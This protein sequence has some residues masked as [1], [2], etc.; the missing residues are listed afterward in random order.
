MRFDDKV[1]IVTGASA[2]IG[3]HA[4]QMF[5]DEGASLVLAAR[6]AERLEAVAE[7]IR[8]VKGAEVLA[9]P[10]DVGDHAQCLALID[11]TIERFGRLDV[12]VNNAGAHWRGAFEENPVDA[13]ATMV[14]VNLR[15]PIVLTRHALEHVR[16]A[17]GAFVHVAS[18]AGFSP[19]P[20]SV[21]YSATKAGLRAFSRALSEELRGSG[22]TSSLVSPGPV[23]TGFIMD[24]L[25]TVTDIT[26]SQP[27]SSAT[28]VAELVIECAYDG[29]TERA[30]PASSAALA[31]V[32]YLFPAV[33]RAIRPALEAKGRRNKARHLKR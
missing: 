18:I 33:G 2:G 30:I 31:T 22:A 27:L 6:G 32:N 13:F 14:D 1:V 4:A 20:G 28:A 7:E 9:L 24:D 15:A 8:R 25:E 16:R 12:L 21:V 19:L 3:M 23:D 10:T 26:F 5:A 11:A 29:A 17:Q